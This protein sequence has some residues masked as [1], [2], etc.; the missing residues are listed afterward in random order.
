MGA[1]LR[2]AIDQSTHAGCCAASLAAEWRAVANEH[3]TCW[4]LIRRAA[5]GDEGARSQ[6]THSYE[7]L[8]RAYLTRRWADTA[9]AADVDD[10]CQ[11]VLM[12]CFDERGPLQRADAGREFRS[13]LLGIVRN[14][15]LRFERQRGR[16]RETAVGG[17]SV[18]A[19]LPTNDEQLS[20]YFDRQWAQGL[21][22][23]A[24]RLVQAQADTGDPRAK[25]HAE[26]LE[27]RFGNGLPIRD[28]AARWQMDPDAVHRAY[29]KARERFRTCL[30]QV[31]ALHVQATEADLDAE[32]AR[33]VGLL[34]QD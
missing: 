31:V 18:F 14:V 20:G 32:C 9:L 12:E 24:R 29:A 25:L 5:V 22:E 10:A 19:A 2:E 1:E 8:I 23:E 4:T 16:R 17:E 27:L 30:R 11:E 21:V 3:D 7:R 33:I 34:S 28:I 6:F 26:L 15:A 13:Y